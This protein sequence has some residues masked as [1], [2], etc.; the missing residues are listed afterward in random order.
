MDEEKK[1]EQV[2]FDITEPIQRMYEKY[3]DIP[4][5]TDMTIEEFLDILLNLGYHGLN[6][7]VLGTIYN[8]RA[9]KAIYAKLK[10][11]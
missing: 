6:N 4:G 11:K 2:T 1:Y 5:L 3:K 8:I 9:V 7:P 10:E